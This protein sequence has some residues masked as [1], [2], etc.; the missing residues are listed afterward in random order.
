MPGPRPTT[1]SRPVRAA[2]EG[3]TLVQI[4]ALVAIIGIFAVVTLR[5]LIR[6][7]DA[8]YVR[9]ERAALKA[10][11]EALQRGIL[12]QGYIPD[13]TTGGTGWA[14][15]V[16]SETGA[17][18]GSI[19]QNSRHQPRILLIDTG[20]LFGTNGVPLPYTQGV[21]GILWLD[22]YS[23]TPTHARFMLASSVGSSALP[24]SPGLLSA[25][26]FESLWTNAPGATPWTGFPPADLILERI[27]LSPHI[28]MLSLTTDSAH[29]LLRKGRYA[30]RS[31]IG[32]PSPTNFVDNNPRL[33]LE[34]TVVQLCHSQTTSQTNNSP[35]DS[36]H[37]LIRDA[38]FYYAG[39]V[40]LGGGSGP[41]YGGLDLASLAK[42]FLTCVPN[43]NAPTNQ[44]QV[45]VQAMI[46]FMRD[47]VAWKQS[48]SWQAGALYD[49]T[50][51]DQQTMLFQMRSI[52]LST[53][54]WKC[55]PVNAIAPCP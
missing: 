37:V 45:I 15:V 51:S 49:Q 40:W 14:T 8:R 26:V 22:P 24:I 52:F 11:S 27:D 46:N 7:I 43:L 54:N 29:E 33:F 55:Y 44:Q 32:V 25:N 16:A 21:T 23:P 53:N 35:L 13:H 2:Q 20:D 41:M 48:A 4:I 5:A 34:S 12:R 42:Q 17:D 36:E 10:Y 9:Q 1:L 38:S 30:I 39:N 50:L 3:F 47:Y 6:E 28:L 31:S 18:L 19:A